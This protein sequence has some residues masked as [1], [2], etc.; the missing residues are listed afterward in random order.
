MV[1]GDAESIDP[2]LLPTSG[3]SNGRSFHYSELGND[4]YWWDNKFAV[5]KPVERAV[6]SHSSAS[7][8]NPILQSSRC[9]GDEVW[10]AFGAALRAMHLR[11]LY[12]CRAG[13]GSG[14]QLSF[15]S[16][17]SFL[18]QVPFKPIYLFPCCFFLDRKA[19]LGA[20]LQLSAEMAL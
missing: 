7:G 4:S 17:L 16:S 19:A 20:L 5:L 2:K 18:R 13:R 11:V 8:W 14:K 1:N 10:K 3:I 15:F 12:C 6:R 9:A